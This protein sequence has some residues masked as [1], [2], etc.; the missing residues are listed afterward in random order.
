MIE[1]LM[2]SPIGTAS[3]IPWN[4]LAF[5]AWNAMRPRIRPGTS[6]IN[7]VLELHDLKSWAKVGSALERIRGT[8]TENTNFL[9]RKAR[10][11]WGQS[12][13]YSDLSYKMP[14][15][16]LKMLKDIV[17]RLTGAH[18]EASFGIVP[19]TADIVETYVAL[20]DLTAKVETLKRYAGRRQ[21]RYFRRRFEDL[22]DLDPGFA[23][24]AGWQDS[25]PVGV[26]WPS[27]YNRTEK[28]R[29]GEKGL[30][31]GRCW[32]WAYQ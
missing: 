4:N 21:K 18:L 22:P 23:P 31:L 27:G 3:E 15:G 26:Q 9:S 1:G 25:D 2:S 13:P 32:G 7:F 8:A 17:K 24:G 10:R 6:L 11:K 16:R 20:C 14:G 28:R 30:R 12:L 5:K 19:F 29:V